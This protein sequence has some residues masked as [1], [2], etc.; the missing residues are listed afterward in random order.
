MNINVTI[1]G[2]Q[3]YVKEGTTIL[4]A[5]QKLGFDIPTFCYDP[6][7]ELYGGCRICVVEVASARDLAAS[8]TTKIS[9]GMVVHTESEKVIEA[10]RNILMLFLANHPNDCLT[11][12]KAGSCKLQEYAYRYG[13]R[14]EE[15]N[16]RTENYPIEDQNPYI[17]RDMNKCIL[18]GKCARSC[19]Q[20]EGRKVLSFANRGAFTKV[21]TAFD[22]P[23]EDSTCVHCY[24]C[25]TVCPVGALMDKRAMST[26]RAWD[27]EAKTVTCIFCDYGCSFEVGMKDGKVAYV[28]PKSPDKGRPL[29]LKGKIGNELKYLGKP[30]KPY[31]K[32]DG[33]FVES[34]WSE[35]LGLNEIVEK[36]ISFER[37]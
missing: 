18:C 26:G 34:S 11:C 9:D 6:T 32:K 35:A 2:K 13:V 21:V 20:E 10:R 14:F 33:K 24:R 16:G 23:Y 4:A 25:V 5:A 29:C 1:N 37:K 3:T 15:Q 8:C 28:T 31:M 19:V 17:V 22:M 7:L 27:I 12:Q 30:E 36:I